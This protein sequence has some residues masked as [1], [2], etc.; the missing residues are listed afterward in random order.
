MCL[1][2]FSFTTRAEH[3]ISILHVTVVSLR[4]QRTF[5]VSWSLN[6]GECVDCYFAF[7]VGLF[8]DQYRITS[9]EYS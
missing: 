1:L 5:A 4:Q 9:K 6:V 8:M 2:R 3:L 7:S